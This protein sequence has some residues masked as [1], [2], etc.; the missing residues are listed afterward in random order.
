[1]KSELVSTE[2]PGLGIRTSM[3]LAPVTRFDVS[4]ALTD[5]MLATYMSGRE[6]KLDESPPVPVSSTAAQFM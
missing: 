1:V 3:G 2:V 6:S 4:H 5:G